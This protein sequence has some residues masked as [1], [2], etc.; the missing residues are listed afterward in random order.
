MHSVRSSL[1]AVKSAVDYRELGT[2]DHVRKA[3]KTETSD[4]GGGVI[5]RRG[6]AMVETEDFLKERRSNVCRAVSGQEMTPAMAT[7]IFRRGRPVRRSREEKSRLTPSV[8]S[9]RWVEWALR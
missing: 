1:V 6:K 7:S 5:E 4:G 9:L 3:R 8:V 2:D